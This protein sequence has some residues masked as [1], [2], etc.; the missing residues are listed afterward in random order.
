MMKREKVKFSW[1]NLFFY[2]FLASIFIIQAAFCYNLTYPTLEL[3]EA[4]YYVV[5]NKSLY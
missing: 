3:L 1:G 4:D 2:S 5:M